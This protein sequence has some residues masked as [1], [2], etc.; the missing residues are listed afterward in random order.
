[1]AAGDVVQVRDTLL[2]QGQE[3]TIEVDPATAG[4]NPELYLMGSTAGQ[5]NTYVR[6]RA[7]AVAQSTG[8][9]AGATETITFTA[10]DTGFY[11]VVVINR[12]G[13]GSYELS[14]QGG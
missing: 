4:Q 13:S 3:V 12:S 11:G 14:R 9:G 8:G 7:Q 6:G 1:M 2:H 10:P 5:P